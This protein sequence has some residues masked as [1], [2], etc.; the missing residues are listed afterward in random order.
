MAWIRIIN[1]QFLSVFDKK[2][3][4]EIEKIKVMKERKKSFMQQMFI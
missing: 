1:A 4:I 3:E 2:I